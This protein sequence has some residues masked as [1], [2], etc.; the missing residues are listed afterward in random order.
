MPLSECCQM[1][2]KNDIFNGNFGIKQS[3]ECFFNHFLIEMFICNMYMKPSE[4]QGVFLIFLIFNGP[5]HI[6]KTK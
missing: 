4:S 6:L 1:K 5:R 3:F 2:Y